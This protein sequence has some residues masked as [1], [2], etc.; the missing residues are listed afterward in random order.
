MGHTIFCISMPEDE[1]IDQSILCN[2]QYAICNI[3]NTICNMNIQNAI[4]DQRERES[5]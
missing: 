4:Y 2:M 3:C 5:E 1:C